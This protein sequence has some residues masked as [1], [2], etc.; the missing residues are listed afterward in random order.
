MSYGEASH[1]IGKK[2]TEKVHKSQKEYNRK[3][4]HKRKWS[5]FSDDD[6]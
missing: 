3:G 2:T 5:D 1:H 6:Y 4:K